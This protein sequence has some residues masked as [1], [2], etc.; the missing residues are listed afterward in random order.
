MDT[1]TP[2]AVLAVDLVILTVE[3]G[4]LKVVVGP[5]PE[6]PYAGMP[7]LPGVLL[8]P[9]ETEDAAIARALSTKV[10]AGDVALERVGVFS[11]PGRDPRG[12]VVS[13]GWAALVTPDLARDVRGTALA[14]VLP[15]AW[16]EGP[17]GTPVPLAFDHG[18]IL[19]AALAWARRGVWD[20][21]AACRLLPPEFPLRALKDVFEAILGESIPTPL[22]DYH[23]RRKNLAV[24][25]GGR[26]TFGSHRRAALYRAPDATRDTAT[27]RSA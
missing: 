16:V 25:T 4:V 6:D 3:E 13:V 17:A 7:A 12:R 24:P 18:S 22:F 11:E 23:V 14:P 8:R 10:G 1:L 2:N 21:P 20:G 19:A 15:S 26:G 9:D 27:E 5:R